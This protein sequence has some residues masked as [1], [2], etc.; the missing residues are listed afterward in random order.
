MFATE[1]VNLGSVFDCDWQ[2]IPKISDLLIPTTYKNTP[3][4]EEFNE[5]NTIV[6]TCGMVK[7]NSSSLFF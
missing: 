5:T 2:G 1:I 7:I 4:T 6:E 3:D